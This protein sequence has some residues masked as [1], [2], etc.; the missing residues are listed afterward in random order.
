[1]VDFEEIK[2]ETKT[3]I[4]GP[5]KTGVA[6]KDYREKWWISE[7]AEEMTRKKTIYPHIRLADLP[8][9]KC[10]IGQT[11]SHCIVCDFTDKISVCCHPVRI[12]EEIAAG[13]ARPFVHIFE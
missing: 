13:R 6:V 4:K 8:D 11:F 12:N 5:Y 7:K 2:R 9:G 1:M 10:P 3:K